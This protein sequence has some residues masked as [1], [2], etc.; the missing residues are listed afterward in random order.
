MHS[1]AIL[2]V[3][4]LFIGYG[5]ARISLISLLQVHGKEITYKIDSQNKRA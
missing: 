5:I 2:Q 3:E 4:S 1:L